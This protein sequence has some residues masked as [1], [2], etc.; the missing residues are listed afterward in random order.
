MRRGITRFDQYVARL[1]KH[2]YRGKGPNSNAVESP[3]IGVYGTDRN[4]IG[5]PMP[6]LVTE[7]A[8]STFRGISTQLQVAVIG[9]LQFT[10]IVD[11]GQL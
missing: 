4:R 10:A 3:A 5:P 11:L 8:R 1:I 7:F 6:N 2:L 9:S